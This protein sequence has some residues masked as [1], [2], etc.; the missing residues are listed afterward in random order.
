[1]AV[2]EVR[3]KWRSLSEGVPSSRRRSRPPR[4]SRSSQG[5]TTVNAQSRLENGARTGGMKPVGVNACETRTWAAERRAEATSVSERSACG[6]ISTRLHLRE[7]HT[8]TPS[9]AHGRRTEEGPFRSGEKRAE[10]EL[11]SA[12]GK[13]PGRSKTWKPFVGCGND[14]QVTTDDIEV[15]VTHTDLIAGEDDQFQSS[16]LGPWG[17]AQKR[18]L[19]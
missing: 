19:L 2:E 8:D 18:R 11:E 5:R 15:D 17:Q 12:T 6:R 14:Q 3:L 13:P 16:G 9:P 10:S 7:E 1:M 4:C